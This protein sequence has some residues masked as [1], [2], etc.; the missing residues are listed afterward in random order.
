MGI[1]SGHHDNTKVV[2]NSLTFVVLSSF[3]VVAYVVIICGSAFSRK[4]LVLIILL[5]KLVSLSQFCLFANINLIILS[6]VMGTPSPC[7]ISLLV[8]INLLQPKTACSAA[9]S[10]CL[11]RLHSTSEAF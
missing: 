5:K 10:A 11:H 2:G 4:S 9:S 3:R 6:G 7:L 1:G 8:V